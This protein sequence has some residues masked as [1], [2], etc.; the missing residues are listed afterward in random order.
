MKTNFVKVMGESPRIK[1]LDFLIENGR[2]R[3]SLSELRE[4]RV[5]YST[6]KIL[7]P[8]LLK[9]GIVKIDD[10]YGKLKLYKI[11]KENPLVSSIIKL[12]NQINR[13]VSDEN[14]GTNEK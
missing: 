10:V 1:V 13:C 9:L 14:G 2:T 8:E 3:W 12:Y 6:L 7:M 5:G 11:N 4:A